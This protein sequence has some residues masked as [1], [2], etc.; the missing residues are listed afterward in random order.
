[1]NRAAIDMLYGQQARLIGAKDNLQG[2]LTTLNEKIS[3]LRTAATELS[4]QI[5]TLK[6]HQQRV[7]SLTVDEGQWKGEH[8]QKFD[9][10]YNAYKESDC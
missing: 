10:R 1:M 7:D 3:R 2:Q 4:T 9:D 8:K 5:T 6:G